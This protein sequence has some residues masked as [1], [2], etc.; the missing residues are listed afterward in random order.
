MI[1]SKYKIEVEPF[2]STDGYYIRV[3]FPNTH[4]GWTEMREYRGMALTYWGAR[5]GAW[6]RKLKI[7][8]GW[9]KQQKRGK[10]TIYE[11]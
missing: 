1:A 8:N 6:W 11:A 4:G 9:I 3:Y 10:E 7:D 2:S 5:Y